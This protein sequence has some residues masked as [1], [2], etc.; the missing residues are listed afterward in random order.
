MEPF[1]HTCESAP[2]C[3]VRKR[4]GKSKWTHYRNLG[5]EPDGK[6]GQ[7]SYIAKLDPT[8]N[9]VFSDLFG[10]SGSPGTAVAVNAAGQI[11]VTGVNGPALP[12]TP[13]FY[14]ASDPSNPTYL[15]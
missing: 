12:S 3:Q 11:L 9:L 14:S 6:F 4:C 5:T 8:G 15:F 13:G 2:V 7:Q 10:G 1:S